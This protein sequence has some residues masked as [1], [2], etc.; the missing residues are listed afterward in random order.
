MEIFQSAK[1]KL[2]VRLVKLTACNVSKVAV[3]EN[4]CLKLPLKALFV[5]FFYIK[6][7]SGNL[8]CSALANIVDCHL[9]KIIAKK[10]LNFSCCVIIGKYLK[11]T[12]VF[13]VCENNSR[14]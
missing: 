6:H 3:S 10:Q 8:P 13:N 1:P 7:Y 14:I 12:V 2:K 11:Q 9:K 4:H 5:W